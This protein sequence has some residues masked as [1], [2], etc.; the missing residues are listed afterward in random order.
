MPFV[1]ITTAF[2]YFDARARVELEPESE[3]MALPAEI[4]LSA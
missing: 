4:E 1:G 3:L 2:V